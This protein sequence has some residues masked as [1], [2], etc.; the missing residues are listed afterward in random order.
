MAALKRSIEAWGFIQPIV[1]NEHP[2]RVGVLISGHQRLTALE[3]LIAK[4]HIPPQIEKNESGVHVPAIFVNL[5]IESEKLLNIAMNKISGKWDEK[6][7]AEIIIE[8][9]E[10][11]LIPATGFQDN[12]ISRILDSQ[13]E[14]IG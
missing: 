6:K 10:S 8:N 12:E 14:K 4:D 2:E 13:F 5:D 3:Q 9:K 1:V 11:V 7:L